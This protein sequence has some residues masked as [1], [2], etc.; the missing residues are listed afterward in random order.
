MLCSLYQFVLFVESCEHYKHDK[1]WTSGHTS[2]KCKLN[3]TYW[4]TSSTTLLKNVVFCVKYQE[5][6]SLPSIEITKSWSK[7]ECWNEKREVVDPKKYAEMKEED[8]A[9]FP[10]INTLFLAKNL[11]E[12]FHEKT[13]ISVNAS[14]IR[15]TLAR[16]IKQKLP[17]IVPK[18]TPAHH[19]KRLQFATTWKNYHF[20]DVYLSD[21]A[22]FQLHRNKL[23]VWCRSSGQRPLRPAP[24]CSPKVMVWGALSFKGF[25]LKIIDSGTLNS[26]KYCNIVSEFM[27]YANAFYPDGWILEQDGA[28]PILPKRAKIFCKKIMCRF[29]SGLPI[30][31]I[32]TQSKTFGQYWKTIWRR[33]IPKQRQHWLIIFKNL[34]IKFQS[35]FV[36]I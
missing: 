21:E 22:V 10:W 14:T 16:V 27:P 12:L 35:R 34:N 30:H 23:E 17:K 32:L 18:L 9:E 1:N 5:C 13:G 33:K 7:G 2:V 6:L 36:V 8:C 29:C 4:N 31:L 11:A 24:K 19:Q 28:T 26:Q 25:Y 15:R 3:V 20:Q